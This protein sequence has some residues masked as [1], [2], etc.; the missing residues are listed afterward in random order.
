MKSK[1]KVAFP[2]IFW[3]RLGGA[4]MTAK[5]LKDG[6]E[7]SGAEVKVLTTDIGKNMGENI[8][9][10]N[11]WFKL[12]KEIYLLGNILLDKMLERK[13]EEGFKKNN[14]LPDII[15]VQNLYS[16]PASTKVAEKWN[17][18]VVATIREPLPKI[19]RQPYP[20][21]IKIIGN[22]IMEGRNKLWI[23]ILS[24]RCNKVIAV[25]DF[26]KNRLLRVGV[27]E[28]KLIMIYE[29][30]TKLERSGSKIK[31]IK[32]I[33]DE[34]KITIY[35]PSRLRK[36][37]GIHVLIQ[38]LKLALSQIKN[39]EL[40][41]TGIGPYERDL[42]M[43]SQNLNLE[44][45]VKFLGLVPFDMVENLYQTAD[46]ICMPSIWPE[47]LSRVVF[48]AMSYGKPI[49]ISKAGGMPEVVKHNETG[50]IVP[51]NNPEELAKA[52]NIIAENKELR[53]NMGKETKRIADE[54][55]NVNRA[56]KEHLELYRKLI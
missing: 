35:C 4:E 7:D 42:K 54:F 14:F 56:A 28:D 15:H 3:E 32:T 27:P 55:F 22:K 40:I 23:K 13:I 33:K 49:I 37:K 21:A 11:F 10:I 52:I 16:L 30:H 34:K 45:H 43:L 5:L 24:E 17:I 36:S 8:I 38:A 39:I 1:L 51:P 46:I 19:I 29:F 2:S 12:P 53:E 47:P 41:I 9:P 18:P 48:E 44:E 50:L 31:E 6:L 26:I 25:S 20:F